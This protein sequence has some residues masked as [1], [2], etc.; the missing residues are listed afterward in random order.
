MPEPAT[1]RDF[2]AIEDGGEFGYYPGVAELLAG[3]EYPDQAVAVLDRAGSLYRLVLGPDRALM[4]SGVPGRVERAWLQGQWA[5]AQRSCPLQHKVRRFHAGSLPALLA[6]L[7]E[8]LFLEGPTGQVF[9]RGRRTRARPFRALLQG[10]AARQVAPAQSAG[11]LVG[12]GGAAVSRRRQ[13]KTAPP[14]AQMT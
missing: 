6:E 3:C 7:F 5:R 4:M 14:M 8:T 2:V 10:G 11:T 1:E 9:C 13:E 12:G